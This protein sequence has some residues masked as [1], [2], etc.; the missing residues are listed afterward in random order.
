M[1]VQLYNTCNCLLYLTTANVRKYDTGELEIFKR[2]GITTPRS[3]H[4]PKLNS[5]KYDVMGAPRSQPVHVP[6]YLTKSG[7]ANS[8][9]NQQVSC[10][11][12][13]TISELSYLKYC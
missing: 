6:D 5:L 13:T 2:Q 11:T 1:H 3:G 7:N 8:Y 4:T 10:L 12:L 9:P